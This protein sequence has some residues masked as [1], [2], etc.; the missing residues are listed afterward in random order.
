M[1]KLSPP[2]LVP[3]LGISTSGPTR[4]LRYVGAKD[5]KRD[6]LYGTGIVWHAPG[7]VQE[8]P[9][10][11]VPHFLEHPDLWALPDATWSPPPPPPPDQADLVRAVLA[12]DWE[13][14]RTM[15]PAVYATAEGWFRGPEAAPSDARGAAEAVP[16][17]PAIDL[18]EGWAR[19]TLSGSEP[20][21]R[22]RL[23]QQRGLLE[24]YPALWQHLV[25][26]E[27]AGKVRA[28]VLDLLE[29]LQAK[30]A[31]PQEGLALTGDGE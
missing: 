9:E 3:G 7:D 8:V 22:A 21:I 15:A 1:G 2:P 20:Q 12:G 10:K 26:T 28:V 29:T 13:R 4:P 27:R 5:S 6:T 30:Q 24:R 11:L 17:L 31:T 19:D 16:P 18:I 25:E 23:D 14:L